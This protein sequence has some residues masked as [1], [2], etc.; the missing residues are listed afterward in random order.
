[1]VFFVPV[2]F[3]IAQVSATG[4][5]AW[6][7]H[8]G[9]GQFYLHTFLEETP[10]LNLEDAAVKREVLVGEGGEMGINSSFTRQLVFFS[11]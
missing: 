7:F 9:R 10:D 5:S 8:E 3:C 11:S 1:M 6:T 2:A 4:L